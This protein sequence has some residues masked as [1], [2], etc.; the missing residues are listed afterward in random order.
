MYVYFASGDFFLYGYN[1]FLFF[2]Y[3]FFFT[4]RRPVRRDV[5]L[6]LF[7][8]DLPTLMTR[9]GAAVRNGHYPSVATP[10]SRVISVSYKSSYNTHPIVML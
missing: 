10:W 6:T 2:L 4:K 1:F 5:F 3:S 8:A 7:W 9:K